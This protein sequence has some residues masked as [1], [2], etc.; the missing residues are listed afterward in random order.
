M[1]NIDITILR[2]NASIESD[3]TST[4]PP[5]YSS[6]MTGSPTYMSPRESAHDF[7]A[8]ATIWNETL[9]STSVSWNVDT[10]YT[11]L[12]HPVVQGPHW[13]PSLEGPLSPG[14]FTDRYRKFRIS[15]KSKSFKFRL[16]SWSQSNTEY[17]PKMEQFRR[18]SLCTQATCIQVV[19][20]PHQCHHLTMP[21]Q[22]NNIYMMQ[23]WK[24]HCSYHLQLIYDNFEPGADRWR[25]SCR[26]CYLRRSRLSAWSTISTRC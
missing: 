15:V 10:R 19:F 2:S 6:S 11:S 3:D 20:Q 21:Q 24:N 16:T 14:S 18:E 4:R 12:V 1:P 23:G 17:T 5:T 7:A 13:K 22:S 26:Y 8:R 9:S 25:R